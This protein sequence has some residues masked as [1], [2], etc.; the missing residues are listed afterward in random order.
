MLFVVAAIVVY[1]VVVAVFAVRAFVR[2][3]RAAF[4]KNYREARL[5]QASAVLRKYAAQG[6]DVP[7]QR[8]IVPEQCEEE[9]DSEDDRIGRELAP[10]TVTVRMI[11]A[12]ANSPEGNGTGR[13][14]ITVRK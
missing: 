6:V 3:F 13:K 10:R 14:A 1:V 11:S 4:A 9:E 12:T 8:V 2:S 7:G 5:R